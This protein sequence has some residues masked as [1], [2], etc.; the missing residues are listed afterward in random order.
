MPTNTPQ[1]KNAVVTCCSH[2]QGTPSVRVTTSQKTVLS[3]F[4]TTFTP[5][6]LSLSAESFSSLSAIAGSVLLTSSAAAWTH[7]CCSGVRLFQVFSLT[8]MQLLFASC[9]VIDRIGATS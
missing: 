4:S 9:S 8:Q 2:S 5:I 7:F 3:T 6:V 1:A